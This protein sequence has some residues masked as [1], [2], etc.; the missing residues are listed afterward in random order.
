APKALAERILA[1][2]QLRRN[3]RDFSG[4]KNSHALPLASDDRKLD[5][6][7]LLRADPAGPDL[8]RPAADSVLAREGA[9]QTDP[10]LPPYVGALPPGGGRPGDG[11]KTWRGGRREESP[12]KEGGK[13]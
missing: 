6:V 4:S 1:S 8:R 10:S 3:A 13:P 7:P 5:V 2:W 9:G 11:E 12:E